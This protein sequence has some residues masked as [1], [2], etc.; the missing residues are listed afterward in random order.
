VQCVVQCS[1]RVQL[2]RGL[3]TRPV[4]I[5]HTYT[6]VFGGTV[7]RGGGDGEEGRVKRYFALDRVRS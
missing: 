2:I 5:V 4:N 6:A 1:R 7:K 3:T